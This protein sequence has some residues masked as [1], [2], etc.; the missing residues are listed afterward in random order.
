MSS[1]NEVIKSYN[2][3]SK[4]KFK[5]SPKHLI[6]EKKQEIVDPFGSFVKC[7]AQVIASEQ[8]KIQEQEKAK[9]VR[10][11]REVR[12]T[13][14]H[15]NAF[16]STLSETIK[17]E[18]VK[19]QTKKEDEREEDEPTDQEPQEE[20]QK[21]VSTNTSQEPSQES[22]EKFEEQ[23]PTQANPYVG[24]LSKFSKTIPL[25]PEAE[26]ENKLKGLVSK[27]LTEEVNK[28][29]QLFPNFGMSGSGGGTNAVQYANGGTMDG[30]LNVTG[31]YLSGGV[32]L[33]DIFSST[34]GG[35]GGPTDRLTS[36]SKTAILGTNGTL[37]V[38]SINTSSALLSGGT[39]LLDIFLEKD[40][41]DCG[42]YI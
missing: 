34:G 1:L 20:T 14:K 22:E 31:R 35:P 9:L 41:V 42:F 2:K 17:E 4:Q 27:Q 28:I 29:K 5:A 21:S 24:E 39:N 6:E 18:I 36:G 38:E 7:M 32:D 10:E 33:A 3:A 30:D 40:V 15:L 12:S 13:R 19:K 26:E 11:K 25:S 37:T 8:T 16:F 23:Q